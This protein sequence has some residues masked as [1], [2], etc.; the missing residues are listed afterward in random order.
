MSALR[1]VSHFNHISVY[2]VYDRECL[3]PFPQRLRVVHDVPVE[4]FGHFRL[5]ARASPSRTWKIY[6]NTPHL[7]I[8]LSRKRVFMAL[9]LLFS[10]ERREGV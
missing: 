9:F 2:F 3:K 5:R 4:A 8:L 7:L 6:E 10:G 1:F